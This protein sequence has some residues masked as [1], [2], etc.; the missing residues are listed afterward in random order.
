LKD[1]PQEVKETL[2]LPRKHPSASERHLHPQ[3]IH[4]EKGKEN[5]ILNLTHGTTSFWV[6]LNSPLCS[7]SLLY[8]INKIFPTS[9]AEVS[10]CFQSQSGPKNLEHLKFLR[11]S[12][13]HHIDPHL[14]STPPR[15][16]K[17][18]EHKF[19]PSISNTVRPRKERRKKGEKGRKE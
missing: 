5:P 14:Q 2:L 6:P 11:M 10:L 16:L 18:K 4:K 1:R 13:V 17:Q 9:A 3:A 19:K 12:A 7:L 8:S 15:R